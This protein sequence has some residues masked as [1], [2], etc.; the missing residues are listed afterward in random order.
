MWII[1][2][3]FHM[4]TAHRSRK[5]E[6]TIGTQVRAW[7]AHLNLTQGEL[8][9]RAGLAHNAV[10]RIEKEE[11]SP[12]LETVEKL[13]AAMAISIEQLQF[14]TPRR[15]VTGDCDQDVDAAVNRLVKRIRRLPKKDMLRAVGVIEGMLDLME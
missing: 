6:S 14:G 5:P 12:K 2:P 4:S 3:D 10:S 11:V 9:S 8:E 13:A 7:R 15:D 1:A